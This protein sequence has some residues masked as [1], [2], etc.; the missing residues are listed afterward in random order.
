MTADLTEAVKRCDICQQTRTAL[1]KWPS[2]TYAIPNL[3][4]QIVACDCFECDGSHYLIVVDLFSDCIEMKQMKSLSSATFDW[5]AQGNLCCLWIH[6]TLISDNG[7]N[8]VS[9]EFSD[10]RWLGHPTGHIQSP[11]PTGK[12]PDDEVHISKANRKRA[13]V[14]KAILEWGNWPTQSQGSS[15]VQLLMSR[16]TR[17]F[18]PCK[19]SL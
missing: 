4:W 7:P 19:E 18:L 16:R 1:L 17:S 3:P 12:W 11:S 5:S 15:P 6:V 2:M 14:W 9:V 13:D 10:F 8:Y